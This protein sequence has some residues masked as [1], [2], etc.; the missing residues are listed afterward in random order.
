MDG[1]GRAGDS[2]AK[3][4]KNVN[5]NL[6]SKKTIGHIEPFY[7]ILL[8]ELEEFE[9]NKCLILPH[10]YREFQLILVMEEYVMGIF[11]MA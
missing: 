10:D 2:E 3:I 5:M 4:L 8:V 1:F 11:Y 9:K 6:F 7:K